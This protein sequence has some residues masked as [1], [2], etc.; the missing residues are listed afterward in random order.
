MH[1]AA[2]HAP[3]MCD[4]RCCKIRSTCRICSHHHY[5]PMHCI[6][7]KQP[8]IHTIMTQRQRQHKYADPQPLAHPSARPLEGADKECRRMRIAGH[9][10]EPFTHGPKHCA[11]DQRNHRVP[12]CS[13][14]A[15]TRRTDTQM[16]PG[17]APQAPIVSSRQSP[18]SLNQAAPKSLQHPGPK[19]FMAG[20][21]PVPLPSLV[22]HSLTAHTFT[23]RNSHNG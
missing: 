11:P 20:P 16:H 15:A 4:L 22:T 21:R 12:C 13:K 1:K 23:I 8:A 18:K 19:W 3:W 9:A 10:P 2:T 7:V 14:K 17:G 5:V 6:G